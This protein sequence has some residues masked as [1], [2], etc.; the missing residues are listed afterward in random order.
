MTSRTG[1]FL[2]RPRID[3]HCS[4]PPMRTVSSLVMPLGARILR[5]FAMMAA[6]RASGAGAT[7]GSAQAAAAANAASTIAMSDFA[8]PWR[9]RGGVAAIGMFLS[10]RAGGR[11]LSIATEQPQHYAQMLGHKTDMW[12]VQRAP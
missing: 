1:L 4:M 8:A 12:Q 9:F 2:S 11:A 6:A 10:L 7:G 5:A 3:T